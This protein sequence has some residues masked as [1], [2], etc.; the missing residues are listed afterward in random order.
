MTG[1]PPGGWF[2]EQIL[3]VPEAIEAY[4]MGSAWAAYEEEDKGSITPGKL[5]DFAVLSRDITSIP[6]AE[7]KDV[8][9]V[10]TILGGKFIFDQKQESADQ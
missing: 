6:S 2:P 7:I 3:T 10:M 4:T 1:E 8:D 9:V 5:A